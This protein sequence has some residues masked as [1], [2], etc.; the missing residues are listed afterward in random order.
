M[1]VP[2]ELLNCAVSEAPWS[3]IIETFEKR[4]LSGNLSVVFGF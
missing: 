2:P 1:V 4:P 3:R